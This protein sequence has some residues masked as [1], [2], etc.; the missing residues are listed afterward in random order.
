MSMLFLNLKRDLKGRLINT[1]VRDH[2][3]ARIGL[4]FQLD[5]D[6]TTSAR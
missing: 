2:N 5:L 4:S 1:T 6:G 3:Q